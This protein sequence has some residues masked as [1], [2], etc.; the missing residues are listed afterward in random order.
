MSPMPTSTLGKYELLGLLATG[1]MGEI[2][3]ARQRGPAGFSKLLVV[4]RI[5]RHLA[6]DPAFVGMFLNEA[7]LAGLLM[8]PNI[9]QIYE[10]GSEAGDY[11]I[12]MEYVRGHNLRSVLRELR[13][14]GESVDPAL[15][16]QIAIQALEGLHYAHML[17]GDNGSP[18]EI[19]HRDVSP[20]N[21]LV[22]E[23]GGIKLVDF[24]IA[25]A[26]NAATSERSGVKGKF[27]YMAPEQLN[28]ERV[29]RRA[30]VYSVGCI[31]YELLG[32]AP[33]FGASSAGALVGAV[34]KGEAR[35]LSSLRPDLSPR[36][37][38][39]VDRA[40]CPDREERF[41]TA[42]EMAQALE[43]TLA[44]AGRVIGNAAIGDWLART[45]GNPVPSAL[46]HAEDSVIADA[47]PAEVGSG[48]G[49]RILAGGRAST[50]SGALEGARGLPETSAQPG[51]SALPETRIIESPPAAGD[52]KAAVQ[53]LEAPRI[54]APRRRWIAWGAVAA[55]A[56]LAVAWIAANRSSRVPVARE[57]ESEAR[58]AALSPVASDAS[59]QSPAAQAPPAPSRAVSPS[60]ALAAADEPKSASLDAG[61]PPS[62][63]SPEPQPEP[64][65]AAVRAAPATRH[66]K[67][68]KITVLSHPW[69]TVYWNGRELG[70]TPLTKPIELPAGRQV[71]VLRNAE[72]KLEK[73]VSVEVPSGG[74]AEVKVTLNAP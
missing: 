13:G 62:P 3:L 5:L 49:T 33:R 14:R 30:D 20:D 29:D 61:V 23:Q 36:L 47:E 66:R 28:G 1:G 6:S 37:V 9:V 45:M 50:G 69:S 41:G 17:A 27:A 70:D 25:K 64:S 48:L 44:E 52:G 32:G 19:V 21:L 35:A 73:R 10:L 38:Q 18:L 31:L 7:K 11:F 39:I 59:G 72:L 68:G 55:A 2:F 4:K 40:V 53:V 43:G 58:P 67:P 54:E 8:H 12:A 74:T 60:P 15:S 65:P 26:L 16:A 51:T 34:L 42:R 46:L 63:A 57:A 56:V 22:S 24:G 71:L